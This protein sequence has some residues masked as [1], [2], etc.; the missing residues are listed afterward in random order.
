MAGWTDLTGQRFGELT[1]L[2]WTDFRIHG[3]RSWLCRCDCGR[4]RHCITRGLKGGDNK[5]CGTHKTKGFIATAGHVGLKNRK[6]PKEHGVNTRLYV[7]WRAMHLRCYTP[8]H[9]GFKLYGG[10]G[11]GVCDE[12]RDYGRFREWALGSDYADP[13]TIDRVDG[14]KGY[15]PDNCRWATRSQQSR[16]RSVNLPP[17]TAFGKTKLV[18]EWAED[19]RCTVSA[20]ALRARLRAGHAPEF[21][22]TA[23]EFECRSAA[24]ALKV[25][26]R[27]KNNLV[28]RRDGGIVPD[29]FLRVELPT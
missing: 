19:P 2:E 18:V 1:V 29:L 9:P 25:D 13:L 16:N 24:A 26:R 14:T 17:V 8:S 11:I 28:Q 21:A 20:A 22:I 27:N 12:W 10:R 4:S 7:I 6:F 23:T 3:Q 15:S 5:G